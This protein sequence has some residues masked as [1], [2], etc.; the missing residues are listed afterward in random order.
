[1]SGIGLYSPLAYLNVTNANGI[2]LATQ[3]SS[4]NTT[5][6]Q[7]LLSGGEVKINAG[8]NSSTPSTQIRLANQKM[9][10]TSYG[11]GSKNSEISFNDTEAGAIQ[12]SSTNSLNVTAAV[13]VTNSLVQMVGD[14]SVTDAN[15]VAV[16]DISSLLSTAD[17]TTTSY[18]NAL[19]TRSVLLQAS[20][21]R[22]NGAGTPYSGTDGEGSY[23]SAYSGPSR[24]VL[25]AS[26]GVLIYGV[27]VQKDII[28]AKA[29]NYSGPDNKLH[30]RDM[31]PLGAFAR[32]RMLV[33]DPTTGQVKL[34]MAVYYSSTSEYNGVPYGSGGY[35]GDLW[36]IY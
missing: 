32:Q 13:R 12:I 31:Y 19:L 25:D 6:S 4:V 28:I 33:E 20:N 21:A 26:A 34:G 2:G 35:V 1:M 18:S 15:F 22:I 7:I 3:V 16:G 9:Y 8:P 5:T 30:Y 14:A 17:K 24:I 11:S 10:M 27:P 23:V 36:V 29:T